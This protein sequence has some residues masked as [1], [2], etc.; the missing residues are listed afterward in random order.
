MLYGLDDLFSKKIA[1][2]ELAKVSQNFGQAK[3]SGQSSALGAAPVLAPGPATK[4]QVGELLKHA[5]MIV[6]F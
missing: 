5:A 2:L 4:A 1:S 6:Q 3:T